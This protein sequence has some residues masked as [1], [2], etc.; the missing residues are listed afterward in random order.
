MSLLITVGMF[1][2]M[3]PLSIMAEEN[4]LDTSE[5]VEEVTTEEV[6]VEESQEEK[7]EVL[8][9][10]ITKPVFE[11][12]SIDKQG[13]TVDAGTYIVFSLNAY[14]AD[15]EIIKVQLQINQVYQNSTMTNTIDLM[16][17]SDHL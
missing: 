10:D 3:S 14:D 8:G 16:H 4:D 6:P 15:S 9:Y 13:Q 1:F 12:L 5:N 7:V 17:V 2:S 11:G